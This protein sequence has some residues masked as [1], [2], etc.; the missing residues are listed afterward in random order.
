MIFRKSLHFAY[1]LSTDLKHNLFFFCSVPIF[2]I[3]TQQQESHTHSCLNHII[4][5]IA[6]THLLLQSLCYCYQY[7]V[8]YTTWIKK[9]AD[10]FC[11]YMCTD[12]T[13]SSKHTHTHFDAQCC[14]SL[15]NSTTVS[16]RHLHAYI[17]TNNV[18]NSCINP[19]TDFS[20]HQRDYYNYK[21]W[22]VCFTIKKLVPPQKKV[23]FT[24]KEKLFNPN[25]LI[26][27]QTMQR[28]YQC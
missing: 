10:L 22:H 4:Q 18:A 1:S 17:L 8:A 20:Y 27:N 6:A 23:G 5:S 13:L 19:T 28:V 25:D 21:R 15:I 16:D 24:M 2:S 3:S 7:V 14:S 12:T 26:S 9:Q 11:T